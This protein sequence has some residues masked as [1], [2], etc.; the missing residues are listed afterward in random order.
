ME[1]AGEGARATE[2]WRDFNGSPAR[3][4]GLPT[5]GRFAYDPSLHHEAGRAPEA[6][7]AWKAALQRHTA[8][9]AY[10]KNFANSSLSGVTLVLLAGACVGV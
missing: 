8:A 5:K 7:R 4:P 1:G 2:Q 9:G 3:A 10:S 6:H